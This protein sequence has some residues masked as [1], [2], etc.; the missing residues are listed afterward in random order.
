MMDEQR[1]SRLEALLARIQAAA[2]KPRVDARLDGGETNGRAS[3][4]A[5][6][7]HVDD[8][9]QHDSIIPLES[10]TLH[11]LPPPP[12]M[13]STAKFFAPPSEPDP[14]SQPAPAQVV[15]ELSLEPE[16]A[17]ELDPLSDRPPPPP[18][19][20]PPPEVSQVSVATR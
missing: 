7:E 19:P 16:P 8:R 11:A 4:N 2:E 10:S 20:P 9:F 18:P 14:S 5:T 3:T 12:A 1:I 15:K 17:L 13:S 6:G